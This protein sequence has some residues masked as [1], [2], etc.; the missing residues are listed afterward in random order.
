MFTRPGKVDFTSLYQSH[1][2]IMVNAGCG[3]DQMIELRHDL[4]MYPEGGF[5]E[6]KT[7]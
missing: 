3:V 6:F 2:E 7:Q 5:K 1:K 4:H